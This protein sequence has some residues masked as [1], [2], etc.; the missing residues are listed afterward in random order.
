MINLILFGPPGSGKGTQALKLVEKY[1]FL[2]I[3]TGD[4]FRRE[5]GNKTDL[6]VLA[7]SYIKQGKLVPDEVT[8]RML[9]K[10]VDANP[11]VAGYIFDGFPRTIPQGKALNE[12]L[13]SKDMEITAL[14]ELTV[15]EQEIIDRILNRAK[16]SGR[17]DDGD[18]SIIKNRIKVY[19]D[20]TAP[21]FKFYN[22]FEKSISV[23]GMGGI[24]DIFDRLCEVINGLGEKSTPC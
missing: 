20:E 23:N 4:L 24:E 14:I 13:A 21:V 3:S 19:H 1:K 9:K 8:I 22:Q 6:G 18:V 15:E 2:H 10:E 5:I 12:L 17:A 11:D 16:T 7:S